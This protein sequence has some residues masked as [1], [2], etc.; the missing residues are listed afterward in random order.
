M[1][2]LRLYKECREE[3]CEATLTGGV[4]LQGRDKLKFWVWCSRGTLRW[5][6]LLVRGFMM[7]YEYH[8]K[9]SLGLESL[10]RGFRGEG[11]RYQM[12]DEEPIGHAQSQVSESY[13]VAREDTAFWGKECD[14]RM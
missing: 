8:W 10:L 11:A 5:A 12:T 13:K 3:V 6:V 9:T 4:G 14:L 2:G 1:L 7:S